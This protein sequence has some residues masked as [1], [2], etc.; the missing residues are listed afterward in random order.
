MRFRQPPKWGCPEPQ[1]T[2]SVTGSKYLMGFD[3]R[4]RFVAAAIAAVVGI[5]LSSGSAFAA[6][7]TY[8]FTETDTGANI[9]SGFLASTPTPFTFAFTVADALA[10]NSVY[11][12]GVAG[13]ESG[14]SGNVLDLKFSTGTPVSIFTLADFHGVYEVYGTGGPLNHS[15]SRI[16]VQTN[17]AGA[18]TTFSILVGGRTPTNPQTLTSMGLINDGAGNIIGETLYYDPALHFRTTVA[19]EFRCNLRG[20]CGGAFVGAPGGIGGGAGG[21]PGG[22]AGGVPEPASWA[23]MILGFGG[24][25]ATLRRRRAA[26]SAL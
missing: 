24:A 12:F 4:K 15:I 16:H 2:L 19:G 17:G 1:S 22:G 20:Y 14:D 21:D 11:N 5:G 10:A 23:L 3:M 26:I 9:T 13:V 18:I 25:G 6:V 8:T 7:T